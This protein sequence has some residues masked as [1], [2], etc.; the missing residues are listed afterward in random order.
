MTP[1]R[2]PVSILIM[3]VLS[4]IVTVARMSV[5]RFLGKT[6]C[7][8]DLA[9]VLSKTKNASVNLCTSTLQFGRASSVRR[10][11]GRP[12]T[13]LAV[14]TRGKAMRDARR[15]YKVNRASK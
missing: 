5:P 2:N 1:V 11:V 3:V 14:L 8:R 10:Q 7:C 15:T 4:F 9:W 12:T 13:V 6:L